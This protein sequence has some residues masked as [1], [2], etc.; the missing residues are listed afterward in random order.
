M[1]GHARNSK[2]PALS[3]S[4]PTDE[5]VE[6]LKQRA[7]DYLEGELAIFSASPGNYQDVVRILKALDTYA[8]SPGTPSTRD[9]RESLRDRFRLDPDL[10]A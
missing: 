5:R 10:E 7:V 6:A 1:R 8:P 2:K 9:A 3:T 4:R